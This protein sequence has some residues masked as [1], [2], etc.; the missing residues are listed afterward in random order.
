MTAFDNAIDA[1]SEAI[2]V[3]ERLGV[4]AA[5]ASRQ[6]ASDLPPSVAGSGKA[7]I[8]QWPA[9]TRAQAQAREGRRLIARMV[10]LYN[11]TSAPPHGRPFGDGAWVELRRDA[12]DYLLENG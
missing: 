8:G 4:L 12:E 7:T 1:V 5:D 10:E 3:I 6:P 2:R 11:L 9:L